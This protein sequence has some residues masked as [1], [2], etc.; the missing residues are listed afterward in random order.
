MSINITWHGHSNFQISS[1][2]SSII[3]DPFFTGNPVA[4]CSYSEIDKPDFVLVTHIHGDHEGDAIKIC[5]E[6]GA[7]VGAVVGTAAYLQ[8]KG[9]P[10]EQIINGIGWNIGGTVDIAPKVKVTL[11]E[12]FHTTDVPEGA[13]TG[14]II[15]IDGTT[16]YHAGDTSIFANM[17]IWGQLYDIDVALLPMGGTF[18]MDAKQAALAAKLLKTKS[19][20]PMHWKTFPVLAQDTKEFEA[21]LKKYSPGCK[22]VT[23]KPGESIKYPF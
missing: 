13:C 9:I 20:I 16:I 22:S 5:Q 2:S 3:I 6:T 17:E 1:S 19:V 8:D 10:E 12:A 11:T 15:E 7:K 23:L 18:T 21:E 4:V 14:F